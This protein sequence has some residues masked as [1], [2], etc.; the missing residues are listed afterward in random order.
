MPNKPENIGTIVQRRRIE[1]AL[2]QQDLAEMSDVTIKT[3]YAIES[4][5]GNPTI[6]VLR[7]VLDV[8][9]LEIKIQIKS[10]E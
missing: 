3:L 1:L 9:G 10:M 7:R 5:K 6:E 4:N 2:N 8:L